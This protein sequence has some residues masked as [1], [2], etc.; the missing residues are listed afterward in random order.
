MVVSSISVF[1]P[2]LGK[3]SFLFNWIMSVPSY[4][5]YPIACASFFNLHESSRICRTDLD[6]PGS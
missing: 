2:Y 5:V 4:G 6:V 3:L 1:H